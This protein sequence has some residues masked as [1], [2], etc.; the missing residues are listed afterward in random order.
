M[1]SDI[2]NVSIDKTENVPLILGGTTNFIISI[3][4]LSSSI[5]L[6]NLSIFITTPDGMTVSTATQSITSS[7][8]NSDG[9][10]SYSWINLKD[11]A[12]L[13][14][15]YSFNVTVKAGTKFKSG[16][17]IPFGYIFNGFTVTCQ[18]DTMPRG[19]YDIGNQRITNG[20]IMSFKAV[21]FSCSIG[22]SGK[23]LKG[24]GTTVLLNDYSKVY[25]AN[26]TFVNNT[27]SS[28]LVNINILIP[29]GI[30]YIG[31]ISSSGTDANLLKNPT[32]STVLINDK[33]YTQIYFGAIALSVGSNTSVS[34]NYAAWNKYNNNTGNLIYHGTAFKLI[35]NMASSED[36]VENSVTFY[37]MDLI[38]T[39]TV[40]KVTTDV[41]QSI[42]YSYVYSV[43]QY[44]D[45]QN[46][47]VKYILPD[48][49]SFVSS[50]VTPTSVI[51]NPTLKGYELIYNFP[52]AMRNSQ[53]T[54][55]IN[56]KVDSY[57]RYKLIGS[58]PLPVVAFDSFVSIASIS[59]TLIQLLIIVTDSA[60][61]SSSIGLGKITKTFLKGYYENGTAKT[62]NALAPGD[63][64]EYK[65]T[66][67]ASTLSAIQKQVYL[68]DFFPLSADPIDGLIYTYTGYKPYGLSPQLIEPHGVDFNYGDIPGKSLSTITFK[69]PIFILGSSSQNNNLFKLSGSN[70]DGFGYSAR[71]QVLINIGIPNIQL[72]KSITGINSSGVKAGEIYSYTVKITN[73]N[74]LGTET[75]AFN[76]Q[77]SDSLS[78][79]FTV[80]QSS[81]NVTGTG[82]YRNPYIDEKGIQLNIDK[83][84]PGQILT[85]NYSV[86]IN[87]TLA[88]G[89]TILTT[90]ANTNPYSQ[91]D[92]PLSYQYTNQNK[93]ASVTIYSPNI[94]L[95]KSNNSSL[96][97]V[98]STIT[99]TITVTIPQGTVV[100]DAYV[101]D[102]LPSGGQI[103]TG[104]AYRNGIVITP[105]VSGNSVTFPSEGFIDALK[106]AK[107]LTYI[108]N[109]K[110]T[111]SNKSIGVTTSVQT[112]NYQVLYKQKLSGSYLTISK[113]LSVTINHPNIVLNLSAKD[114]TTS[115]IYNQSGPINTNSIIQ[116]TLVFSNN[117]SI[118]LVN[119]KVDIPLSS[120]FP[121]T[122]IN[123]TLLCTAS[124]DSVN[125]KIVM[126]IPSLDKGVS[127]LISFTVAP[128]SNL[129][130]GIA[131][132]TQAAAVQYYNDI[133]TKLYSGEKSNAIALSLS[134]GVSLL[135]MSYNK[136]DDSTS[137]QVTKPG[138]IATIINVFQNTGG[139]YDDY[140]LEIKPV[141]LP[142][143]LSINNT[144]IADILAN[145][146]YSADL[147][148]LKNVA[149]ETIKTITITATIPIK[150]QL[151][152][153]YD[154]V[155]TTRSKTS[156]FPQKTVLNIDPI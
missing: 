67:D 56:A 137:F 17:T 110:I 1:T 75:D 68:D 107:T 31:N 125:K 35:V 44:Y 74:T 71:T 38:I 122:S 47:S 120:N 42:Q 79:W 54:V 61:A 6:Y 5:K 7:V 132:T 101:K 128:L 152:T 98:N 155:I 124:Y 69:V 10:Y 156:P 100:Y 36:I 82:S 78:E 28:S 147:E 21:R 121:F 149:P 151:G 88:P 123:T 34:F 154:F 16:T 140:T 92:N 146:A 112:N 89:L 150:S 55:T 118:A 87:N 103:Y 8:K 119:G 84:A 136:I 109:C 144:K 50:S 66:Y 26:N 15:S 43:C 115:I 18:V 93:S 60:S 97:K 4:N 148:I 12:P 48:G 81:I 40:N 53:N 27:I 64:A 2:L 138:Y 30:R 106:D 24:A 141:A 102:I 65:L 20:V 76:F 3:K 85:L 51:D 145:T 96:F 63:F 94:I 70:T 62:F 131:I 39:T 57:Y 95:T 29:D 143:T 32:I 139:G 133:S 153:R 45:I 19:N 22:T 117:S 13:E 83:L 77:L 33:L 108:L 126:L 25:T 9:G 86:T 116:F 129:K 142:Y 73:T 80:N 104:P 46:I 111:N 105:T 58:I 135:P 72:T 59:G 52:L 130:S 91:L 11:L 134:P 90:A 37:A 99:Y 127:G 23:V 49:I 14:I 114:L 113:N 41:L